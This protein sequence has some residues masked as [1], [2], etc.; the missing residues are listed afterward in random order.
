MTSRGKV[1]A[2]VVTRIDRWRPFRPRASSPKHRTEVLCFVRQGF[3]P[4]RAMLSSFGSSA[5]VRG[6]P[7]Q[8]TLPDPCFLFA[9][10]LGGL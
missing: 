1:V 6:R 4:R 3:Q 2:P 10:L 7:S 8:E 5:Y 9:K